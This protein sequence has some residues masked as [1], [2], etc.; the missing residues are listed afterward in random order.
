MAISSAEALSSE[1]S[2]TITNT[3]GTSLTVTAEE[4]FFGN[5]I[6]MSATVSHDWS[7]AV[8]DSFGKTDT[9]SVTATGSW[10]IGLEPGQQFNRKWP[11]HPFALREV[12]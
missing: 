12:S 3:V 6:S 9:K 1:Q 4:K 5:G 11:F 10:T 2:T 8:S 7:K